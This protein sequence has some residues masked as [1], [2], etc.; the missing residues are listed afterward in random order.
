[1]HQFQSESSDFIVTPINVQQLQNYLSEYNQN[2]SDFRIEG[3][4]Q[5]FKIPQTG[6]RRFRLSINLYSLIG[7]ENILQN[8]FDKENE[9]KRVSGSFL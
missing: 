7:E 8:K 5:G 3:L 6:E 2:T 9:A 4:S 1:M